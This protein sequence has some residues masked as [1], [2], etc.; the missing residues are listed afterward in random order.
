MNP[1]TI[2]VGECRLSY[3]SVFQPKPPYNNPAGELKYSVTA[4]VPKTNLQAKA[5]IDAAI[6]AAIDQGV[7]KKWNGVRPPQPAISIHDGDGGKPSD[8]TPYGPEC[9]GMWVF[10]AGCSPD[11]PPFVVDSAVQPIMQ[12]SEVYSGMYGNVN[13]TFFPYAN[14]G[15]KGVG[16]GLN[17]IQKTRDGEPLANTVTAEDAFE[18][19]SVQSNIGAQNAPTYGYQQPAPAYV[20]PAAQSYAAPAYQTPAATPG[21]PQTGAQNAPTYPQ[22]G[23]PY[24]PQGYPVDPITGQPLPT[25]MPVM[26][27]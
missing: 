2:T 10:T 7:T 16:I 17:G 23:A 25:G 1:S 15:K 8:G 22:Q 9:K 14:S 20:A 12:Q 11:R 26:G 27:M 18:A 19:I 3:V 6:A 13:V 24:A 5:A 4:L 21:Y